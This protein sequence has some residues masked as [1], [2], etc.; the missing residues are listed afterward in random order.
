MIAVNSSFQNDNFVLIKKA[1]PDGRAFVVY[2]GLQEDYFTNL[3]ACPA[4]PLVIYN[5]YTPEVK[6]AVGR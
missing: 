5:A 4:F 2:V 3:N 6:S 1:L